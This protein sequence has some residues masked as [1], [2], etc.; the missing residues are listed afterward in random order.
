M[1]TNILAAGTVLG[2]MI[3]FGSVATATDIGVPFI[4]DNNNETEI[5]DG[6]DQVFPIPED[7]EDFDPDEPQQ[8]DDSSFNYQIERNSILTQDE[9]NIVLTGLNGNQDYVFGFVSEEQFIPVEEIETSSGGAAEIKDYD[10]RP[11]DYNINFN[12]EEEGYQHFLYYPDG[13]VAH[14]VPLYSGA[15]FHNFDT[16][17]HQNPEREDWVFEGDTD[18]LDFSEGYLSWKGHQSYP[19]TTRL[20]WKNHSLENGETMSL[21]IFDN[22]GRWNCAGCSLTDHNSKID[23]EGEGQIE[24]PKMGDKIRDEYEYSDIETRN[25]WLYLNGGEL[26]L[27]LE[28]EEGNETEERRLNLENSE[29]VDFDFKFG[30][31]SDGHSN[32]VSTYIDSVSTHPDYMRAS[33]N[34][35]VTFEDEDSSFQDYRL[36]SEGNIGVEFRGNSESEFSPFFPDEEAGFMEVRNTD[37][38]LVEF[39][40]FRV[41][42]SD[43]SL[44]QSLLSLFG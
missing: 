13:E 28:N 19:D 36:S 35:P 27:E 6:D 23:V 7:L 20:E 42:E 21:E 9:I 38:G 26:V 18:L 17:T 43:G 8:V 25:M 37:D 2:F 1:D 16:F 22:H 5:D 34:D 40:E 11:L 10:L 41:E 14:D 15:I 31:L 30:V 24:I 33:M 32:Y 12:Y 3:V 29:S 39:L 44:T 4:S